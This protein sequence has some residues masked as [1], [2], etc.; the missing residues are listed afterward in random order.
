MFYYIVII[1][2]MLLWKYFKHCALF[3]IIVAKAMPKK[4]TKLLKLSGK[5]KGDG[6]NASIS[7]KA[8][9]QAPS[10]LSAIQIFSYTIKKDKDLPKLHKASWQ[11]NVIKVKELAK[12]SSKPG[13]INEQDKKNRYQTISCYL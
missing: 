3:R 4:L 11:G 13:T 9:I 10:E 6:D 1:V 5:K 8:S 2:E 12:P 7:S